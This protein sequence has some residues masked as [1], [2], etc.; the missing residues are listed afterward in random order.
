MRREGS[1]ILSHRIL[2]V[3]LLVVVTLA[4]LTKFWSRVSVLSHHLLSQSVKIKMS[5]YSR[6]LEVAELAVST[7]GEEHTSYFRYFPSAICT[8]P[9]CQ[10]RKGLVIA[11]TQT[12]FPQLRSSLR[13]WRPLRRSHLSYGNSS[14]LTESLFSC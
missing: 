14:P 13:S 6:E 3:S 4:T 2:I 10:F 9:R 8:F 7:F 1:N 11:T 12:T 5:T